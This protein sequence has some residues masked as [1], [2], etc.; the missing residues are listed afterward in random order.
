MTTKARKKPV[1]GFIVKPYTTAESFV[2]TLYRD[3]KIA[4]LIGVQGQE[5]IEVEIR[6]ITRRRKK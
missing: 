6:P 1:T 3:K 2:L 4:D 5:V